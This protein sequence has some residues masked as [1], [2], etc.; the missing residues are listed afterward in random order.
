MSTSNGLD[1]RLANIPSTK[2]TRVGPIKDVERSEA[3][4]E[5]EVNSHLDSY[6]KS[7]WSKNFPL[8]KISLTDQVQFPM[9]YRNK[10]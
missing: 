6:H 7:T 1:S 5:E 4:D 9:H 10:E 8:N 2:S 3:L